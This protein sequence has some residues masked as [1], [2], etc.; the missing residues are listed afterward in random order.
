DIIVIKQTGDDDQVMELIKAGIACGGLYASTEQ[1][2]QYQKKVFEKIAR[3]LTR[4]CENLTTKLQTKVSKEI[5]AMYHSELSAKQKSTGLLNWRSEKIR[6]MVATNVFRI[7]INIPDIHVVIHAGF[8]IFIIQESGRAGRDGLSAKAIIMYS[9]K[10]IRTIMGI[11]SNG[12][13]R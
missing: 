9:R 10:D 1:Q 12:Q 3:E 13:S 2:L 11:Y 5:I 6:I 8:S 4:G 7:G